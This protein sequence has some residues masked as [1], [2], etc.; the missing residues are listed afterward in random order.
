MSRKNALKCMELLKKDEDLQEKVKGAM[1]AYT[2]EKTDAKTVFNVVLAP[3]AKEIGY[4]CTFEDIEAL[5][6]SSGDEELTEDEVAM[7]AGGK[8]VCVLIGAGT[9][10][11]N[12]DDHGTGECKIIG[13]GWGAWDD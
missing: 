10:T 11:S 5:A 9:G 1:E 12:S 7:V 2:G 13:M 3:I 8:A 6:N 4:E